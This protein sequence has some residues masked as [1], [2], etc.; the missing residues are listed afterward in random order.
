MFPIYRE[1]TQT[2]LRILDRNRCELFAARYPARV[3]R[4]FD[5]IP[6]LVVQ[7]LLFIEDRD[8]LKP[9]RRHRNP[10]VE[11]DRFALAVSSLGL[12]AV[13]PS[14]PVVGA[15]T[16]AT[17]LEKLRHSPGGLTPSVRDKLRQMASASLRAYVDGEETLAARRRLVRDY[18][19]ALPLAASPGSGEVIGLGDGLWSWWGVDLAAVNQLLV[20]N[21]ATMPPSRVAARATAYRQVLSLFLAINKPSRYR[22]RDP[23]AL[24]LRT[25]RYLHELATAGVISTRLRDEGLKARPQLRSRTPAPPLVPF[26]Q[27]KARD[28]VRVELVRLL[29]LPSVYELD[30]LDLSVTTTLD[31]DAGH[32]VTQVLQQLQHPSYAAAAGLRGAQ[33][34]D[35]GDPASL[36]YS[37]AVYER[38]VGANLLRVQADNYNQPLNISE[39]TQL[40][41]GSTAKLRTLITYLDIVAALHG[42]LAEATPGEL[43]VRRSGASDRLTTW[44]AG[45][46]ERAPSES[47]PN[48]LEAALTR[49]Y[50]ASPAEGFFTG[51]GLHHFQNVSAKDDARTL[52]VREA[53][54][55]S[56]NLVFVRLMRDVAQYYM[57]RVPGATPAVLDDP[58][59]PRRAVYLARFADWEGRVFINR[60]YRT[61]RD[62]SPTAAADAL[63]QRA[64]S[65]PESLAATY[66]LVRPDETLATF[67][68]YLH[69]RMPG[70]APPV[71][72]VG[73]PVRVT[74][75]IVRHGARQLW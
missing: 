41:L 24:E 7:T 61:Y 20:A 47:L 64:R 43:A 30:R 73:P 57:F 12:H 21:E 49:R 72:D 33:L 10:E 59:D 53:F 74:R 34:L 50:S 48:M 51:A 13:S 18:I 75:A 60:F 66:R 58:A 56:V 17:Q 63:I 39:G 38:G 32:R 15:S 29:G 6:P 5:E 26:R 1:K 23:H 55:R 37:V 42:E 68:A 65:T 4:R 2:G 69:E 35:F 9:G 46:L 27:R 62:K 70:R 67:G 3:Y 22:L 28:A 54:Q 19:N 25:D 40:E 52:T 8:L 14:Q 45:Y 16:L 11:W 31:R 36:I 44:A 71:E